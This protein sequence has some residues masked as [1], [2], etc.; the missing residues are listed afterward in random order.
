[1]PRVLAAALSSNRT[2]LLRSLPAQHAVR[3]QLHAFA[4]NLANVMGTLAL[5]EEVGHFIWPLRKP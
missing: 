4:Y 2:A 3:L 1:M 5:P